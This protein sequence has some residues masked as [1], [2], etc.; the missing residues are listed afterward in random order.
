MTTLLWVLGVAVGW[1]LAGLPVG[2]VVGGV[3]RNRDR[4]VGGVG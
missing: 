1:L 2:Y 3:I 4:Q